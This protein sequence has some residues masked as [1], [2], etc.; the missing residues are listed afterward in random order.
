MTSSGFSSE[1]A[2]D[3]LSMA[4]MLVLPTEQRQLMAW[5]MGQQAATLA[6]VA[7][8]LGCSEADAQV[9]LES[10]L[11]QGHVQMIAPALGSGPV[12][13]RAQFSQRQRTDNLVL[14]DALMSAPLAVMLSGSGDGTVAPDGALDFSVT[15]TN[16]GDVSAIIDIFLDDLPAPLYR[17]VSSTQKRLALGPAQSG[18]AVFT[19]QIPAAAMPGHYTY[20][21]AVDAP[22]HYPHNPPLRF[23]QRLQVLP[24]A[25][26]IEQVNDPTFFLIPATRTSS[27]AALAPG[28]TLDVQVLVHNR[29]NRVD[30][31]RLRC[32]DLPPAWVTIAYPQGF[33]QPGLSIVEQ[34]LDLNPGEQGTILLLVAIPPN[35]LAGSYVGT[36]QL[37]SEN[38][39]E[40]TLLDL[41]YLN[42]L[43]VYQV[44]LSFRTL[45]GRVQNQ[46]GV[47]MVQASNQG[48]TARS[49]QLQ[50]LPLDGGDL[51]RFTLEPPQLHLAAYQT[52]TAR[53][54][55][56]PHP[57]RKRPWVGGG[58]VL[59]FAVEAQDLDQHP[60]PD[61]PMPGFL[62][63]ESRPWWQLLPLLLLGV[64]TL[65]VLVWLLWWTL[66]RRPVAP[67]V[68]RLAP[69]DAEYTAA[70]DDAVRLDFQ[71][72]QPH[73]LQTLELMGQSPEGEIISAPVTYDLSQGLPAELE[74]FCT[75]ARRQL[76]CR[77]LLTDARQPGRYQFTLT[78]FP[79][80][81]R[82]NLAPHSATSAAIA[83]APFPQPEILAFTSTQ[84]VYPEPPPAPARTPATATQVD[85]DPY[86]IRLNWTI[87]HPERVAALELVGRDPDGTIVFPSVRIDLQKSLPAALASSCTL[88]IELVCEDLQTGI[89]QAGQYL[90]ELTVI[91]LDGPTTPPI[92]QATPPIRIAARPPQILSFLVNGKP[93]QPNYTVALQGGQ[94]PPKFVMSWQVEANPGT[95]VVLLPVPGNVPLIGSLPLPI[96]PETS[97]TVVT[98]QVTN[99]AGIQVQRSFTLTTL[100]PPDA[101]SGG[102]AGS[103]G[104]ASAAGAAGEGDGQ[105]LT[106][107]RSSEPD[108][109][110]PAELPPQFD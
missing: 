103:G 71:V 34:Y 85:S 21:L 49:L 44:T 81:G 60:L 61:F 28:S 5:L 78:V 94:L 86:G 97:P 68:I 16:K 36:L 41:L 73:R 37:L 67:Q 46:P 64:G 77:N 106:T 84:P 65:A 66:I 7:R 31:F 2:A 89:R 107:P 59:N 20:T 17:W 9:V 102:E 57:P 32:I 1:S 101:V 110:A 25:Q 14:A 33:E 30:R 95:T 99:S 69:A 15:I 40:L 24:A 108:R 80:A 45:V 19:F 12:Q 62:L 76:T 87:A 43:P 51:C 93:M 83:I 10:L 50:A 6:E 22:Q 18:E 27:P 104:A 79:R 100:A 55:V 75:L 74:P 13:Y 98:L 54:L 42:V 105:D 26:D 52:Q 38:Q 63:W 53:L 90:F 88:D 47:F 39:P 72:S 23:E 58:R 35:T 109:L 29:G 48:N 96:S 8:H 3:S 56:Q 92:T 82:G 4:D 91:P 70:N 11:E